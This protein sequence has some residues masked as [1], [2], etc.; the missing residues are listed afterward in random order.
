M[1][2]I[3]PQLGIAC[4]CFLFAVA[5]NTI[6]RYVGGGILLTIS[7]LLSYRIMRNNIDMSTIKRKIGRK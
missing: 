2:T 6:I 1:I 4:L 5:D 7:F 3:I